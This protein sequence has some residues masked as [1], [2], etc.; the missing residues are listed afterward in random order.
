MPAQP[1]GVM[2][3]SPAGV[4]VMHYAPQWVPA[5]SMMH[6]QQL[7]QQRYIIM[8][9]STMPTMPQSWPAG[10]Q[11]L[12]GQPVPGGPPLPVPGGPPFLG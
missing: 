11:P 6:P 4:P 2:A 12:P 10:A 1:A 9:Q 3:A 5:A 7:A 8:P